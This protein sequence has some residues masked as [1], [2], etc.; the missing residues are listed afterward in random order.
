MKLIIKLIKFT[1]TLSLGFIIGVFS[2]F[3]IYKNNLISKF[4]NN[5]FIN[6]KIDMFIM[7]R[8]LIND[9][10]NQKSKQNINIKQYCSSHIKQE[11][12]TN[13]IICY[14]KNYNISIN[15][16]QLKQICYYI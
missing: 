4:I 13:N 2:F 8:M 7:Q 3:Y 16:K 1:T 12:N 5:D 11:E 9:D 10:F 15:Q 6:S 14:T